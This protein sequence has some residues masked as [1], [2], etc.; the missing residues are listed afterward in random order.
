MSLASRVITRFYLDENVK[1]QLVAALIAIGLDAVSTWQMGRKG[2]SDFMQLLFAAQSGRVLVTHDVKDF[3]QLHSAW[4]AWSAAWG[5]SA[6]ARHPGI[7]IIERG[8]G[9]RGG[10]PVAH[11]VNVVRAFSAVPDP[12]TNRLF[13]WNA[14]KGLRE[15]PPIVR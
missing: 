10:L 5:V 13:A 4:L 1:E 3:Q 7:L 11:M 2:A 8:P 6:T 12:T 14:V 15:V 9:Q